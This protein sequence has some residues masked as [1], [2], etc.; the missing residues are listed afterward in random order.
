MRILGIT[1]GIATGKSTVTR[2]LAD[3][4]APTISADALAHDLLAPG[5]AAT[6]SVLAAF[7]ACAD[8]ADGAG[9][10]IDRRA[11]GR[12]VFADASAR[13]HLES[14]THPPIIAAL[15][16]QIALW[17][18]SDEAPAAAAEIPLL[19][20]ANLERLVD[21]IVVVTCSRSDQISRMLAR[22]RF[23]EEEV[24]RQLAAQ[25]PLAKKEARADFLITSDDFDE[26]MEDTQRQV[27][28]LWKSF[29]VD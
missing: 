29:E 4:G 12:L 21:R 20:E 17:R 9:M 2:M 28:A 26:G 18:A 25:W 27:E 16:E 22:G 8:P 14:L 13:A 24:H 15:R 3:L 10:T 1:G 19:F 6:Q 23:S 5:T 11:L 7:P